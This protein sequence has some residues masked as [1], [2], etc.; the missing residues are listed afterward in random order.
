[1]EDN[2][3]VTGFLKTN[4][5]NEPVVKSFEIKLPACIKCSKAIYPNE[6]HVKHCETAL[7]LKNGETAHLLCYIHLASQYELLRSIKMESP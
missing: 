6:F 7:C 1:M 4:D 5:K 2:A 3:S